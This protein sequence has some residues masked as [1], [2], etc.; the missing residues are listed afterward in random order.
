MELH[1]LVLATFEMDI[2]ECRHYNYKE[3]VR[4]E[5]ALMP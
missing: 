4:E 3:S 5:L 1:L 2:Y